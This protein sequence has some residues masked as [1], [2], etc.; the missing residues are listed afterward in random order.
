V[1]GLILNQQRPSAETLAERT[2]ATELTVLT[3]L[4]M[5]AIIP[6][7]ADHRAVGPALLQS[8]RACEPAL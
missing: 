8:L 5:L 3:G 7:G 6:P 4:P 1:L 2:A